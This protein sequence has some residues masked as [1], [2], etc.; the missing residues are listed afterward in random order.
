MLCIG[1]ILKGDGALSISPQNIRAEDIPV[2]SLLSGIKQRIK[3]SK[4]VNRL[5]EGIYRETIIQDGFIYSLADYKVNMEQY[6]YMRTEQPHISQVLAGRRFVTPNYRQ[7]LVFEPLNPLSEETVQLRDPL[8]DNLDIFSSKYKR[9]MTY[10]LDGSLN[11]RD[12][13]VYKIS[14]KQKENTV[15]NLFDGFV[16]VD[17][18]SMDVLYLYRK[19]SV[20]AR[21]YQS[22]NSYLESTDEPEKVK[23]TDN[24]YRNSYRMSDGKNITKFQYSCVKLDVDG[25]PIAYIREFHGYGDVEAKGRLYNDKNP[26]INSKQKTLMVKSVT[27]NPALWRNSTYLMPGFNMFNQAEYLHEIT[28]YRKK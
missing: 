17:V 9:S 11:F 28:F 18:N 26:T 22:V 3:G 12:K 14:F 24:V 13:R 8:L 5:F 21:K 4:P 25:I 19:T 6:G 27:Y 23:F 16:L 1:D 7:A 2:K 20:A 10:T 15:F